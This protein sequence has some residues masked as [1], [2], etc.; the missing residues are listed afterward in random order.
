MVNTASSTGKHSGGFPSPLRKWFQSVPIVDPIDRRN[1]TL[2]RIVLV[3]VGIAQPLTALAFLGGLSVSVM[4]ATA[5]V[6]AAASTA[7][8]WTC[9]F[10]LQLGHFRVAT[11]MFVA[12]SLVLLA[13]GYWHW[14]FASQMRFQLGQVYP[15][16]VGG[17]LLSR[18]A[19]WLCTAA[20]LF[21]FFVGAWHDFA[22]MYYEAVAFDRGASD[23]VQAAVALIVV[24]LI[25]DRAVTALR[26]SLAIAVKRGSE[27][28]R[29]RDRMQLEIEEKERSREQMLHAQK[30]QAVGRLAS[31]VAHD[32]NH[33]L[34][35][36]LGYT[37]VSRNSRD[38]D[39]LRQAMGGIE[40]AVKRANATLYKLLTFARQD[41]SRTEVFDAV[42]AVDEMRPVFTQL[43]GSSSRIVYEL[44][45][46]ELAISFDRAQFELMLLN[47]AA[48]ANQAMPEGGRFRVRVGA[49][50]EPEQVEIELADEGHG[51]S[52]E[53][54]QRI[55][56]PFF[57]TKPAG[58]GTGLGLSTVMDMVK[59][60][61]G[62]ISV[63]SAPGAGAT[64]RILLSRAR[65]VAPSH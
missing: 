60:N 61:G 7:I 14:G 54:K 21:V 2:L 55:F 20:F 57:T 27:L 23:L 37:Q 32:F 48:N 25:L 12:T 24:A 43:F 64:F 5:I 52:E 47:I 22:N 28:A 3:F 56:E 40:S 17:L 13:Y 16:L 63:D 19:L 10:I 58:L 46:E 4:D 31:G 50:P 33:I 8:V 26:D 11:R 29:V 65:L 18:R 62:M 6:L 53:I 49:A 41:L 1:A 36:I 59:S 15:V 34:T 38:V 45:D 30:M 42:E 9:F 51:M 44:A 35:L 39:Q